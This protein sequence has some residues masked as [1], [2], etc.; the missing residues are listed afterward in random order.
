MESLLE[1]L[2]FNIICSKISQEEKIEKLKNFNDQDFSIYQLK[3][4]EEVAWYSRKKPE[5]VTPLSCAMYQREMKLYN[6]LLSKNTSINDLKDPVEVPKDLQAIMDVLG[7]N[8]ISPLYLKN[9][10]DKY[11]NFLFSSILNWDF[12]IEFDNDNNCDYSQKFNKAILSKQKSHKIKDSF[13]VYCKNNL[14]RKIIFDNIDFVISYASFKTEES[15][16]YDVKSFLKE[17]ILTY[18]NEISVKMVE[19]YNKRKKMLLISEC[20]KESK[21]LTYHIKKNKTVFKELLKNEISQN[22]ICED[23]KDSKRY[24]KLYH[25]MR[26]NDLSPSQIKSLLNELIDY[27]NH[28]IDRQILL[29]KMI[30]VLDKRIINKQ[31]NIKVYLNEDRKVKRI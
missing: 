3:N 31:L 16:R 2:I 12:Y 28:N 20:M 7:K 14:L 19:Y 1:S 22:M 23:E 24:V 25:F 4:K 11:E 10:F 18:P 27:F 5:Y 8:N 13:L 6:F 21:I 15:Y 30:S 9:Y 26:R 29:S 17:I